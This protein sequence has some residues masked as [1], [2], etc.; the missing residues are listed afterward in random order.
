MSGPCARRSSWRSSWR[1]RR[2]KKKKIDTSALSRRYERRFPSR[3][4]LERSVSLQGL[5][6]PSYFTIASRVAS[7]CL[8]DL[9][10]TRDFLWRSLVIFLLFLLSLLYVPVL[11]LLLLLRVASF[12][13]FIVWSV[14][15]LEQFFTIFQRQVFHADDTNQLLS[16]AQCL[17]QAFSSCKEL[18]AVGLKLNFVFTRLVTR[19]L[20]S[21]SAL[22]CRIHSRP[23]VV[24][25]GLAALWI[26]C[27]RLVLL[28][29]SS[30]C[31]SSPSSSFSPYSHCF[32]FLF[33]SGWLL[34]DPMVF[35]FCFLCYCE[36]CLRFVLLSVLFGSPFLLISFFIV[37]F[38]S[39]SSCVVV[40]LVGCLSG[41]LAPPVWVGG[42][43]LD[44][45]IS[46]TA[47]R[48]PSCFLLV[49]PSA[50][51][52]STLHHHHH[53]SSSSCCWLFSVSW[54]STI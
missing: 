42:A 31:V 8:F 10:E 4:F 39:C 22:F 53:H 12:S 17:A 54:W 29:A 16:V 48:V 9:I 44:A 6:R 7:C 13:A 37:F 41:S 30:P 51:L 3:T 38:S 33:L 1:R 2:R 18:E 32:L 45:V 35:L 20:V 43:L 49:F 14:D 47:E 28:S 52:F 19:Q 23:A 36:S 5:F 25:D 34:Q 50:L 40:W 24:L 15:E 26:V 11:F 46:E 21:Q 27:C